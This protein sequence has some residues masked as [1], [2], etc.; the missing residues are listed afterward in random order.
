MKL[1]SAST[2]LIGIAQRIGLAPPLPW[3]RHLW[4]AQA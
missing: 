3:C 2:T 1:S 4:Q